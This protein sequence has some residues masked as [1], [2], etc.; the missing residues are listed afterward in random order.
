MTILKS[1]GVYN[2]LLELELKEWKFHSTTQTHT[3]PHWQA[4]FLV[5]LWYLWK[6][7]FP[8]CFNMREESTLEKGIFLLSK[9]REIIRTL[10]KEDTSKAQHVHTRGAGTVGDP[11]GG[12]VV[13]DTDD[14]PQETQD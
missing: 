2:I 13:L 7:R 4:K 6:W 12:W 14:R 3:D 1:K 10:G 5:T 8:Y 11:P 9:F